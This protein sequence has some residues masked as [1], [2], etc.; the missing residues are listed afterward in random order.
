L[1][2][3]TNLTIK[4]TEQQMKT[5]TDQI[6]GNKSKSDS[7]SVRQTNANTNLTTRFDSRIEALESNLDQ[8]M[9]KYTDLHPDVIEAKNIL[10]SLRDQRNTE[11][12]AYYASGGNESGSEQ[13]G[14]ISSELRLEASRLQSLVA[15]LKVRKMNYQ[16]K[17]DELKQKIDLVPQVEAEL[18]GLDRDYGITKSKYEQLLARKD[19][20]DLAK[21][22]DV[23]SE[24]VKF[25]VIDPPLAPIKPTGPNRKIG[26]TIVLIMGLFSGVGIAFIVSQ[27]NP[28]LISGSQLTSI[29]AYPVFGFVSHLNLSQIKKANRTRL[30]IFLIS[31]G[32]IVSIYG[33]LIFTEL[34]QIN[35]YTRI[36]S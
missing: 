16:A 22:A 11:I 23:S 28:I 15:S 8:L 32:I 31:C 21:K 26:Y 5:L 35:L 36:F 1:L 10:E 34:L 2:E 30:I 3:Q 14:S 20:A 6:E 33:S 25:R 19:S 9:L 29:T 24:D 4:E 17:I 27:L 18:T 12:E 13:I 7:F